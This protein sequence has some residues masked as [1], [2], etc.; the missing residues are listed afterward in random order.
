M[1]E[2]W[3]PAWFVTALCAMAVVAV[4]LGAWGAVAP[5]FFCFLP[6]V[7]FQMSRTIHALSRRIEELERVR[8]GNHAA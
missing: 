5:A 8:Q 1:R 3:G 7:F 4:V 6:V 2:I